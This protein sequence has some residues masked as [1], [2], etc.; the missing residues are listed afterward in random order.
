ML[1]SLHLSVDWT[2]VTTR[3]L[4]F[5]TPCPPGF[6]PTVRSPPQCPFLAPHP[7]FSGWSWALFFFLSV[8]CSEVILSSPKALNIITILLAP[9]SASNISTWWSNRHLQLNN[10][11]LDFPPTW[12]LFLTSLLPL[13]HQSTLFHKSADSTVPPASF[14]DHFRF[15]PGLS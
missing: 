8:L 5:M 2:Q 4:V 13:S 1:H 3:S 11:T 14:P 7:L 9:Y 6:P 15:L 10:T 12:E